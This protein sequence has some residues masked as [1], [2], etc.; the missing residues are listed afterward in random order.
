[1]LGDQRGDVEPALGVPKGM[2]YRDM[3]HRSGWQLRVKGLDLQPR[4]TAAL[5]YDE[6]VFF[7]AEPAGPVY[8]N[9]SVTVGRRRQVACG[10]VETRTVQS[11]GT[12]TMRP[13]IS[14]LSGGGVAGVF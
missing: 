6:A 8:R 4:S 2:F 9:P 13:V 7:L 14:L 12:S 1:M 11:L 3:R 5:E 10:L